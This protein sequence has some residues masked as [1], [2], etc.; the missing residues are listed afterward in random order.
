[1]M[2]KV[3][4]CINKSNATEIAGHLKECNCQFVPKLSSRI[5]IDQY[6]NKIFEKAVRFEAIN[7]GKII[8]LVAIYCNDEKKSSAYITSVS[9]KKDYQGMGIGS[10]LLDAGIKY[11]KTLEFK[12]IELEVSSMNIK[13]I[14]LYEKKNFILHN[15]NSELVLMRLEI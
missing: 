15:N 5:N 2:E 12:S 9:V 3:T 6:A 8:G 10:E 1:M 11:V 4:R 14:N 7:Q 13:A